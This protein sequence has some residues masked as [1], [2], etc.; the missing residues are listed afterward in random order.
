MT[1]TEAPN[2]VLL[3]DDEIVAL[4]LRSG[5]AWRAPLPTV[6]QSEEELTRAA[7]RGWRALLVR[8]LV[9]D[10]DHPA[11]ELQDVLAAQEAKIIARTFVADANGVPLDGTSWSTYYR[12]TDG[13]VLIEVISSEGV[14]SF[15]TGTVDEC[16]SLIT[17][18]VDTV[19]REGVPD[20]S[21]TGA[22]G[23]C[24]VAPGRPAR[25]LTV[26]EGVLRLTDEDPE[27]TSR[28][29]P[30]PESAAAAVAGILGLAS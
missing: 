5:V 27:A 7:A 4:A 2:A 30:T 1:T 17:A 21:E 12:L 19:Q 20:R 8:E 18:A 6:G 3:T 10:R 23:F 11:P 22:A 29:L 25:V 26:G 24:V 15:T 9:V 28:E 13:H 16:S 14:H